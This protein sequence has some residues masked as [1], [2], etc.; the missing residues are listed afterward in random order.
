[1]K[2]QVYGL[3]ALTLG[4][5]FNLAHAQDWIDVPLSDNTWWQQDSAW[6]TATFDIPIAAGSALEQM[7]AMEEGSMVVYHWTVE[8]ADPSLLSA[9]F[10]GHTERTGEEPGTVMFY[11]IHND[12]QETGTLRAPFTGIH[13]W[14]LNNES[15]QDVVVR[16]QVA[17]FFTE[18][19]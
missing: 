11:S 2:N 8:M 3:I 10:H 6:H 4:T 1:M 13:G 7:I 19:E 16:L 15:E 17:G 9:E 18:Q 5:A 14:Y 12:G